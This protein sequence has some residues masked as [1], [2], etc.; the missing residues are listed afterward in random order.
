VG[1]G[2]LIFGTLFGLFVAGRILF[3]EDMAFNGRKLGPDE[4]LWPALGFLGF[5]IVFDAVLI[6]ILRGGDPLRRMSQVASGERSMAEAFPEVELDCTI[7]VA[8]PDGGHVKARENGLQLDLAK[9]DSPK[10]PVFYDPLRPDRVVVHGGPSRPVRIGPDGR[11]VASAPAWRPAWRL[12]LAAL[13]VV[14]GPLG[15]WLIHRFTFGA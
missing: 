2:L 12:V 15:G 11:F 4:R 7:E 8:L 13:G 5:T 3:A 1:V 10:V 14:G 6:L 9:F